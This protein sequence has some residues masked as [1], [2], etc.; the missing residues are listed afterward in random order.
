VLL[1]GRAV[2]VIPFGVSGLLSAYAPLALAAFAVAMVTVTALVPRVR[3]FAHRVQAVQV[4]GSSHGNGRRMHRGAVPNIGGIAI[5]AGF[6]AALFVGSVVQPGLLDAYRVE[7]LAI[8]L[9]GSLMALVGLLDDIWEVPAAM[10]LA[11]QFLAAGILVV[12]GVKIEFI[13]N[14][15]GETPYLFMPELLAV[16]LTLLWVVGF[17]NAFNF[18]DGVD[19]LSSGIAAISSLSLL[20]V[21]LQFADRGASVLLLAALAGAALAFLRHNF[22]PATITMGDSGAYLLGYVLAA[23][24][25]LGALK[26]TAAVTVAAPVLILGLP[27]LNITHVTLRRLRR[28]QNPATAANDHLHDLLRQ[29]SG[30][31]RVTVFVL[32]GATLVLGGLG[33]FL[34]RTPPVLLIAT[35]VAAVVLIAL[36]SALRLAE[37]DREARLRAADGTG[38]SAS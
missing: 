27:V 23:V 36:V 19:G 34:S 35:L 17:T 7:L 38:P 18:I 14:Y 10:R 5:L 1:I 28:G 29:R 24:S 37:V 8:A 20:A 31:Q 9:G 11:T 33:M 4:G 3:A 2:P 22:N 6:L 32:W 25:V 15:F 30:S 16:G 21:A 13:T 26:V 12:N